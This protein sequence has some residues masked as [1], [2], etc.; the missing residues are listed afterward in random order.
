MLMKQIFNLSLFQSLYK[1][2]LE[3]ILQLKCQPEIIWK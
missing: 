1:N 3:F 2:D